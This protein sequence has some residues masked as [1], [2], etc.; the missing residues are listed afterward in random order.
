[1]LH[2]KPKILCTGPADLSML[3][4]MDLQ[5]VDIDIISFTSI[6][7][8]LPTETREE[9]EKLTHEKANVVFTSSNALH[10]IAGFV[11]GKKV[12]WTIFCLDK[13]TY[14]LAGKIFGSQAISETASNASALANKI[15]ARRLISSVYFFCGNL[16]R[17]DLPEILKT[18]NIK[19]NEITVYET[20]LTP[21]KIA[22][23]YDAILFF[24]PGAAE[25]FFT[26]NCIS[27]HTSVFVLGDTTA[28]AVR[29]Y[30][31]NLIVTAEEPG[32][33]ELINKAIKNLV[34]P[35]A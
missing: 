32:K 16:R 31:N 13:S 8:T 9:I 1:M 35:L 24:S 10:A 29:R 26:N 30:T 6:S 3:N 11:A 15:V 14:E 12:E 21:K 2:A 4:R 20:V 27:L 33:I 22:T 28:G 5:L 7:I 18:Q 25:S 19:V 23:Q 34:S 17:N